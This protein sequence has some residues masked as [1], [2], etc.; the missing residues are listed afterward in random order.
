MLIQS[1]FLLYVGLYMMV[2][3]KNRIAIFYFTGWFT[4]MFGI[5]ITGLVAMSVIPRNDFTVNFFQFGTLVEVALL[6]MGLAYRYKINQEQLAE[7]TKVIHEQAKLASMG[8]MLRHIAH[9]WRQPLSEIN[10][11]AMRIETD[12]R[13]KTLDNISLDKNIEQIENLT[14]HMSKTIQDFNGYFKSDKEKVDR[15]LDEV[16]DKALDLVWSGLKKSDIRVDKSIESVEKVNIVE[17]ELIQVL[18]VLLNNARDALNSSDAQEKWIKI[19]VAKEEDGKHIIEVEDSAGGI[20]KENLSK[21][22]EPY[23]STKFE[24][25]G[26]GIGLYMSKMIVEESLDGTLNVSNSTHGAKFT[27]RF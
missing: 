10:S 19:R 26:V 20:D 27:L 11:V 25:Q 23:F 21:V 12:H 13:R 18:L 15:A 1:V 7:K 17:G 4:M 5:I 3:K 22:F 6:S 9:Q 2:V 24:S 8:E 16:V 14:E